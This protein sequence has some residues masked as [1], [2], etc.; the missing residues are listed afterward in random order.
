M[1][2]YGVVRNHVYK[3]N[4]SDIVGMGT[5]VYDPDNDEITPIVPSDEKSYLAAQINVLAWKVVGSDVT[6]GQ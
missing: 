3:V 5:P 2:K 1:A 4:I 6:L